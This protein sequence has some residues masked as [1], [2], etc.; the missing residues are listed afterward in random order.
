[1]KLNDQ[2]DVNRT[3]PN[4][5][6][7]VDEYANSDAPPTIFP[8]Y[9]ENKEDFQKNLDS[10]D[11]V[12]VESMAADEAEFLLNQDEQRKDVDEEQVDLPDPELIRWEERAGNQQRLREAKAAIA[13]AAAVVFPSGK[14]FAVLDKTATKTRFIL[15]R[16]YVQVKP[17]QLKNLYAPPTVNDLSPTFN[18]TQWQDRFWFTIPCQI[19]TFSLGYFSFPILI[20]ALDRLVTMEP[21]D[22]D[23]VTE[24]LWPGVSILY[25]TFVSLTLS[26]LYKRQRDIQDNVA[27]E[28]SLL[29]ILMRNLLS[30]FVGGADEN[31]A[32]DCENKQQFALD[33]AQCVAVQIQTLVRSSRGEE[34][35]R[36]IYADPYVRLLELLDEFERQP[37][38][39]GPASTYL[40]TSSYDTLKDIITTRAKRLSDESVSLPPTHFWTLNILT[41]MLLFSYAISILPT[42]DRVGVRDPSNEANLIFGILTTVFAFFNNFANDLNNPF[43]GVFQVRTSTT[44][45]HLLQL[46]WF[47]VN[48]PVLRGKIDFEESTGTSTSSATS[49]PPAPDS[50]A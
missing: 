22:L 42:I 33:A 12:E 23:N 45:S 31:D 38:C 1:M 32:S 18:P 5:T 7:D 43:Q 30:L 4:S 17:F 21:S 13:A 9:G 50:Q 8:P 35:M 19:L 49:P 28:S 10:S 25:G 3:P 16:K 48:H 29:M 41:V 27:Q 2:Q 44:A 36:L 20:A 11:Q 6:V 37:H 40:A 26:I 14:A 46:K 39:G 34:L 47:M 24:K 15:D